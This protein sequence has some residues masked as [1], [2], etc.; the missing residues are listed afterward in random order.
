LILWLIQ[1]HPIDTFEL[2]DNMV[3]LWID[4]VSRK[5]L[6]TKK[7][8]LWYQYAKLPISDINRYLKISIEG[9][10]LNFSKL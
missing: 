1:I 7:E 8:L 9:P 5:S 3:S 2:V 6:L 4:I 10:M